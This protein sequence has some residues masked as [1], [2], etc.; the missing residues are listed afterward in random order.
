MAQTIN[1]GKLRLDWRGDYNP[2]TAY[3][4]NDIVTYRNQQW[5]CTQ[6]TRAAAF[7]GSQVGTTLTVTTVSPITPEGGV[8]IISTSAGTTITVASTTGLQTGNTFVVSGNAGGGLTATTYYVGNVL[9]NTQLTLSTT[10]ANAIA[11]TYI[12]FTAYTFGSSSVGNPIMTG[13]V[14]NAYGSIAVGQTIVGSTSPINVINAT[15]TGSVATLT[16]ATQPTSTPFASGSTIVVQGITP[17][18]YNGSYVVITST[19]TTVTYANTTTATLQSGS[20]GTVSSVV[21]TNTI[22]AAATGNGIGAYTVSKSVSVTTGSITWSTVFA[23]STPAPNNSY[24]SS[25]SQMFNNQGT[26]TNG[27]AYAVGDVVLYST[28]TSLQ[29]L[30]TT[31]VANYSLNRTV[32][33]AYYCILAHTASNTGTNITPIDSTY[34][35]PMNRK[36]ILNTQVTPNSLFGSYQL[37]VYSN[38]NYSSLVLP[39]RGIAFDNTSQ[40]YGGATKNTTDSPTFGY[41]TANGQVMNW[42]K[43]IN[44]SL[45]YPDTQQLNTT[46]SAN[47]NSALNSM[48]FPFYDYWRSVSGGGSGVHST[49]DG[50]IPRVIQWEKSYDRNLVLMNS[51]EVFAW[52]QGNKGEN[53]DTSGSA[54]GYPVRVGGSLTA[55]YNATS[56]TGTTYTNG[57]RYT[58]GHAWFNVRI[59][60]ISMSGGCGDPRT[61][62]HCLAIDESGQ[63]WVW[64]TNDYGQLGMNAIDPLTS[65]QTANQTMPQQ[66][67]RTAF[68]T[69]ANPAGQSVVAIWACGSGVQGWSYAVTQDGNLWA[70]G[71]NASGQLGDGTTTNRFAPVQISNVGGQ[72]S[73]FFGSGA[74]GNI[75]KIQVLDDA[76]STTYACAA[77]LTSTGQIFCTG[78]N[79]SGWMGFATTP[80]NA[81][82]NIGGGPG[83]A[84]NSAARDFWLYGTGGRYATLLQR[85]KNTGFCWTA[86]YNNYGQLGASGLGN[87]SSNT[88]AISK[89]NVGGTL[90]NLV[91]VKQLAFTSNSTYCTATVVLD[92]GMGFSIGYNLYGQASIGYSQN[93]TQIS[94]MY[95][96]TSI[97]GTVPA[98]SGAQ[99]ANEP[100]GIELVAS[101]VWQPMRTPP[102]MQGNLADCMGYGYNT[103]SFWLMWVNNDGRVMLSGS[104]GISGEYFNPWGQ[105]RIAGGTTTGGS[106]YH[107]ETMSIPITD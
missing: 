69:A 68:T 37:G 47:N 31:V 99:T 2:S 42:G 64:G 23:N 4:T 7:V 96:T 49:P 36:G 22:T 15:G 6:P 16:F 80:V 95:D 81:W 88:Y 77:I 59:K 17:F 20:L 63:L 101:F 44:G 57:T 58:A 1:L 30:P 10:Y 86:G 35:L 55:V 105:I 29:N 93:A 85:D 52:G 60:R 104:F 40:Y 71:Y 62:G 34:W 41:V 79:A 106:N 5:V 92:N 56:P 74:I 46:G 103:A 83:S 54:R 9:S 90:Y 48:T 12:T 51:G 33:Q 73:T 45:G 67:P 66:F 32:V 14:F 39:N 78:N 65:Q 24:W 50:G 75:V 27:Q 107:T 18:G 98:L 53:G 13:T 89:M 87:S 28:P 97:P 100:N 91:N 76:S 82:T 25:F 72:P 84:G 61:N 21:A 3:V 70:W 11:G 38:Q 19:A 102:G 43:D 26:W 8:N 94:N